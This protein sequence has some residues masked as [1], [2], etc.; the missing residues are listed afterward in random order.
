MRLELVFF[1]EKSEVFPINYNYLIMSLIYNAL[2]KEDEDFASK[3]HASS[4]PKPFTFSQL[5]FKRYKIKGD[6]I[7]LYPLSEAKLIIS[8][9]D[10]RFIELLFNFFVKECF[11]KVN[12]VAFYVEKIF[13]HENISFSGNE[14]FKL[15]SPLV[16][17]VPVDV[18][19]KLYHHFLDP[20]DPRF[21]MQFVKNL[22]KK[23][24][25]YTQKQAGELT[26][27]A[28]KRYIDTHKTSKLITIKNTK[29]KGHIFPFSLEGDSKL[30]GFGY[31]AGFGERTAQGFGCAQ[32]IR[33]ADKQQENNICK[34][35]IFF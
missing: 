32:V 29:I 30:I 20:S 24:E 4:F 7:V 21:G 10:D 12:G 27:R 11:I 5:W 26:F 8:S 15:L 33:K 9:V 16:L 17:S 31:Y 19:G 1:Y 3:L 28:D 18:E 35:K 34:S 6:K 23:Y 2:R 25:Y 22:K 13:I 14:R